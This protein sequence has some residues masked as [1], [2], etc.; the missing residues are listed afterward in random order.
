MKKLLG[1]AIFFLFMC[2]TLLYATV[3][4]SEKKALLDLYY[5]T[6]GPG[7]NS[8]WDLEAPVCDWYGIKVDAGHVIE[9]DLFENNLVGQLPES[10]GELKYLQR[11]NMA[12]NTLTGEIPKS[13]IRLHQ[14]KILRFEMNRLI[15]KLPESLGEMESLEELSLFNNFLSGDIPESIG[16]LH[17][18]KVLN[19]SSNGITGEIPKSIGD[20]AMLE[21]LGLFQNDLEGNV[22]SDIGKLGNLRELVMANNHLGGEIPKEFAY[23]TKLEVLQIQN[24]NFKSLLNLERMD[25]EQFLVMDYDKPKTGKFQD[26]EFQETRMV[27][28]EFDKT[29]AP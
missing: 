25:S 18:L 15:G 16:D 23:L 1:F 22:P 5:S 28:T 17:N 9:L 6:N 27:E 7:W 24:N 20:L 12:F 21:S 29:G 2:S 4:E 3:S 14:L 10:L 13:I 26:V 19:L 8:K 11:I